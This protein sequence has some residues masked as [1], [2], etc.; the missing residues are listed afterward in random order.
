[1]FGTGSPTY[2]SGVA[3]EQI[4]PS[5]ALRGSGFRRGGF[6]AVAVAPRPSTG[7][8]LA[9]DSESLTY[10]DLDPVAAFMEIE[11]E[12][13]PRWVWWSAELMASLV[14][15]GFN[16]SSC[17]DIDAVNRILFGGWKREPARIWAALQGL[18]TDGIPAM[19]QLD[20]LGLDSVSAHSSAIDDPEN[21]V[22][23]DGYL[24]PEWTSNGWWLTEARLRTWA[25]LTL[26]T[27]S[28]QRA[29]LHELDPSGRFESTAKSESGAELTCVELEL[30][31]LPLDVTRASTIIERFVGSR[32]KSESHAIAMRQERDAV[33][34]AV[35]P[36]VTERD[37]RSQPRVLA[38][39][40]AT[41]IVVPDTRAWRLESFRETNPFVDALLTW[42]KAE[43]MGSTFGYGWLDEHVGTDGRLRGQWSG[44]DGAAG[45]M[46]AQAGLH[47]MPADL[48]DAVRPDQGFAFVHAD[49]GQIEPR[50]LAAISG[51]AALGDA[52]QSDDL[53]API[54][55]RFGVERAVAKVA[56]LAA[57]YGQTSG[58]AGDVLKQMDSGYRVATQYLK[59]AEHAGREGRDLRTYGGRLVRM[60]FGGN[61][62]ASVAARGRY[63]AKRNGPGSGS[64][65]VQSVDRTR[66]CTYYSICAVGNVSSRR[67]P[68]SRSS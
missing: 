22:R 61:D 2:D 41:G 55:E 24:R 10:N 6:L 36:L 30:A 18:S 67:T 50:V 59:T 42:R 9:T 51:D 14:D 65:V 60:S 32:P 52:T 47:N 35:A 15:G 12:F 48:R 58:V 46:T 57:M 5:H 54:A 8:A 66:T 53:Y 34:L 38:M 31:G 17:W 40:R 1:M 63:A 28:T 68:H 3:T 27:C 7:F 37:L 39:L 23:P 11:A 19:G 49:L 62:S 13:R 4:A 43:R 25:S 44:S 64:R 29:R 56:M 45:R 20:L 33:V 16:V 21:P 26:S